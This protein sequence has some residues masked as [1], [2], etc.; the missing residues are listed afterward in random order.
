MKNP[1]IRVWPF[2]V[3]ALFATGCAFGA[4]KRSKRKSLSFQVDPTSDLF[5][6]AT[7]AAAAWSAAIGRSITVSADGDIPIFYVE[8]LDDAACGPNAYGC[9]YGNDEARIEILS[10]IPDKY[11]RVILT[12]EMGHQI[13][14]IK[15]HVT[16]NPNAIMADPIRGDTITPDDVE[17][18]CEDFDCDPP[19]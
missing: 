19:N 17:F 4:S 6:P 15:G 5:E 8:K 16:T 3:I 11:K 10:T 12:H 2:F 1:P 7:Q 14:G 9:G 18:V 13:K